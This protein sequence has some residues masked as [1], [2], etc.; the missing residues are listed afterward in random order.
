M[1]Q[2]LAATRTGIVARRRSLAHSLP[3]TTAPR[4]RPARKVLGRKGPKRTAGRERT[5]N[6]DGAYRAALRRALSQRCT[7]PFRNASSPPPRACCA[8]ARAPRQRHGPA[9]QL[10]ASVGAARWTARRRSSRPGAGAGSSLP[11]AGRSC[12]APAGWRSWSASS[13][14]TGAGSR[15]SWRC[16]Q[17]RP[18]SA[19]KSSC[20]SRPTSPCATSGGWHALRSGSL[21]AACTIPPTPAPARPRCGPPWRRARADRC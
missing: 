14:T 15:R 9:R 7:M 2:G 1:S 21:R 11:G 5:T 13:P 6:K 16:A 19:T 8:A 10:R 12:P 4:H 17:R 3:C 20:W 18:S